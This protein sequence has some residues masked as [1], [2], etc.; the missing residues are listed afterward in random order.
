MCIYQQ[1]LILPS[2]FLPQGSELKSPLFRGKII[3]HQISL[4]FFKL[5][6]SPAT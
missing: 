3:G 4:W 6:K 2:T 5:K 1:I